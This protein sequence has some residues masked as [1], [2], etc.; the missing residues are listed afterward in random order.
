MRFD[1]CKF[2][3]ILEAKQ[4]QNFL[5]PQAGIQSQPFEFSADQGNLAEIL[6]TQVAEYM[7]PGL[8]SQLDCEGVQLARFLLRDGRTPQMMTR[9]CT[10]FI[11]SVCLG[12]FFG[13]LGTHFENKFVLK[14]KTQSIYCFVVFGAKSVAQL[15]LR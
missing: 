7:E 11:H 5:L 10:H 14:C 9:I 2:D 15:Q 3:L 6:L 1:T 13:A 12:Q 8:V 4:L